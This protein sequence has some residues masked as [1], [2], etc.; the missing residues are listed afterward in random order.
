MQNHAAVFPQEGCI[1][2]TDQD[3]AAAAAAQQRE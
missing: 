2:V 3:L 1:V